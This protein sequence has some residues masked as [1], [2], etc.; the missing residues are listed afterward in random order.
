MRGRA[1]S[2]VGKLDPVFQVCSLDGPFANEKSRVYRPGMNARRRTLRLAA[3]PL[4][5]L[6]AVGCAE[7]ESRDL[8]PD[9]LFRSASGEYCELPEV[10]TGLIEDRPSA[11]EAAVDDVNWFA[12]PVRHDGDDHI[13]AFA[14]HDQNYLYNLTRGVRVRIPDRS[15]AV[16]TP[17]GRF[18][19]VPSSYTP[20][21]N[22]RFYPMRP[23]LEALDAGVDADDVEPAYIHEHP[24][25]K[26]VYYQSTGLLSTRLVYDERV[27]TYRLMFSG[28][29]DESN[30]RVVD[31]RF[32]LDRYSHELK[33][34]EPIGPMALCPAVEN[35]LNTPF[36]SKNGRYVAAYTSESAERGYVP[37]ASL[38]L[39]EIT[40]T[41]P[42]A[43]TSTCREVVDFGFAAGKADFS[44]D[45]SELAFHISQGAYLTPFI[46][47]GL[48]SSTITDIVVARLET[49]GAGSIEG[50][51]E[52]TRLTTSV[53]A[54][55]GSYFPAFFPNGD[56]FYLANTA[57]RDSDADKR[58]RL[59]VVD[60]EAG[61]WSHNV[62]ASSAERVGWETIAELWQ[63]ACVPESDAE[64]APF[65]MKGHE[66]PWLA[67]SLAAEPCA[68]LLDDAR[69]ASAADGGTDWRALGRLCEG[70]A[71]R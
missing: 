53:E 24:S 17:D 44:F 25:M 51:G 50:A 33:S 47:G 11:D 7:A 52:L 34:V 16:A 64:D 43:G 54:G 2:G 31:Y 27:L 58:F 55:V 6:L 22:V 19:T 59:R 13:V 28:G 32:T 39:F 35:D 63:S 45:G 20:D 37:G 36:I 14:S 18:M 68:A 49:D 38:K 8:D 1:T 29:H 41:D 67:L 15:D 10:A 12:R 71:S 70:Q 66:A 26:R 61:A 60:P 3:A 9:L 65:P 30:F 62:F 48:P 57:P 21:Q 40:S 42:D 23:L 5:A 4:S 46:D 69:A 56:L